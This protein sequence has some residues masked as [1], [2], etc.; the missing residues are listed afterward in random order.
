MK[1]QPLVSVIIPT[2]NRE[3][4]I[5]RAIKSVLAQT[6]K[7]FELIIIDDSSTD[8]TPELVSG[9]SKKDFRIRI[10]TNKVNLR[11]AKTLNRG[12]RNARGKYIARLDDDDSWCDS[13]KLQKQVDFLEKNIEYALVGGGIIEVDKRGKEIMRY[14]LLENDEDIRKVILVDNAFVHATVLFR[15]DIWEKVGCYD[16]EFDG[17]EDRDLWLKIGKLSKFYNFQ[18]F[19]ACYIGHDYKNPSYLAKNYKRIEQLK[20]NIK[21]RKKYRN[22]YVGYRKALLLCW[23]SYFYSFLPLRQKIHPFGL[24]LKKMIFGQSVFK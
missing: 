11:L 20:L 8:K 1:N 24:K 12:I 19:F 18:E 14:L 7:N 10:I 21:L 4:Y 23:V 2:Y 16:E 3:R 5:K 6:Y 9:F 17:L 15:K 22:D 13:K